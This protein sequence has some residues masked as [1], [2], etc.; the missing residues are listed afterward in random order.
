MPAPAGYLRAARD[1]CDAAGALLVLDEIQSG[2]GRTGRWFA[3]QQ[4]AVRPDVLTL[5][6]GLGGGLP[7]GACIGLGECGTAL[8]KGDHGSTFGGNPVACA[9]ALAV[10]D[11]IE[12]DGLLDHA[13]RLGAQLADGIAAVHAPAARRGARPGALARVHAGQPGRGPAG[14]RLPRRRV[15]GQRRAAGR[16]QAGAAA[17]PQQRAGG[18]V[19]ARL[20]GSSTGR[21]GRAS[22]VDRAARHDRGRAR[23]PRSRGRPGSRPSWPA[24]RCGPRRNW[25]SCWPPAAARHPGHPLAGPGRT[26]RGA[27]ARGRRVA[28]LR[29]AR[30]AGRAWVTARRGAGRRRRPTRAARAAGQQAG[31]GRRRSC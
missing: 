29:A 28:G 24:R 14:G 23:S 1:A 8:D 27:A 26:R 18:R 6:K 12:A 19:H 31:P 21:R 17:D 2:I 11:T 5:A 20:P 15:P 3:H 13:A 16:D 9:A 10:L 22:R 25:P 30:R 7:I 4:E